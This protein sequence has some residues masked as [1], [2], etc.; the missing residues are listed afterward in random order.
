LRS[1]CHGDEKFCAT[2][3]QLEGSGVEKSVGMEGWREKGEQ[4]MV[5]RTTGDYDNYGENFALFDDSI[6]G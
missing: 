1:S 2:E 4:R 3:K 6:N 5:K